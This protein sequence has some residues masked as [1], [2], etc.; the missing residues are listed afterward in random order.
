MNNKLSVWD[1]FV[2][3]DGLR[4]SMKVADDGMIFSTT[5]KAREQT[6]DKLFKWADSLCIDLPTEERGCLENRP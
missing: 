6:L 5:Q 2:L 4:G 3:L 1:I